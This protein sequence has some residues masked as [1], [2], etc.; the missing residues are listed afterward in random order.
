MRRAMQVL[1]TL[2]ALCL[3]TGAA[4]TVRVH[5]PA[6]CL[7]VDSDTFHPPASPDFTIEFEAKRDTVV[8]SNNDLSIRLYPVP[9]ASLGQTW[10]S[11]G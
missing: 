5:R 10:E 9:P 7:N 11:A 6:D 3:L 8:D 4:C 2:V 1:C